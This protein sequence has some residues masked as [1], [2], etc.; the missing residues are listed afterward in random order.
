[1]HLDVEEFELNVLHGSLN[2][3]KRDRPILSVEVFMNGLH[4]LQFFEKEDYSLYVVHEIC[5]W[6]KDC[7]NIICLP[8][9]LI[10]ELNVS[11]IL[12]KILVQ[13]YF[14]SPHRAQARTHAGLVHTV[15]RRQ[16]QGDQVPRRTRI[17]RFLHWQHPRVGTR[18]RQR[19][20]LHS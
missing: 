11:P 18:T 17:H 20:P 14:S 5:G 9:E 6:R 12:N 4:K 1:M 10:H 2:V 16:A 13:F 15:R 8:K 7:R 19:A 3:L